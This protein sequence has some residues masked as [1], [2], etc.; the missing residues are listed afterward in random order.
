MSPPAATRHALAHWPTDA[1]RYAAQAAAIVHVTDANLGSYADH[2][3]RQRGIVAPYR[4]ALVTASDPVLAAAA[5]RYDHATSS[6]LRACV[7]DRPI[8]L[9]HAR[10]AMASAAA[11]VNDRFNELLG[12]D[13]RGATAQR[14]P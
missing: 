5:V 4:A 10:S 3:R 11:Q 12:H 1:R 7:H 14:V 9:R 6:L 13:P 8:A 2:C